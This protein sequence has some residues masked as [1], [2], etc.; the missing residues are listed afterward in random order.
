MWVGGQNWGVPKR[1]KKGN[2]K[3]GKG[4]SMFES[5]RR[6]KNNVMGVGGEV[7]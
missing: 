2:K 3:A 5:L 4:R 7:P 1:L 6:P